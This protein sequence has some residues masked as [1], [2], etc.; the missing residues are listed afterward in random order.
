[1]D[2]VQTILSSVGKKLEL[3][4]SNI[5]AEERKQNLPEMLRDLYT[6]VLSSGSSLDLWKDS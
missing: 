5:M 1:M 4:F 6:G 2:A 3:M